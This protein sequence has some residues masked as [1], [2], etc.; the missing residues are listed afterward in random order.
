MAVS[1]GEIEDVRDLARV[2]GV[3]VAA[4]GEFVEG[5]PVVRLRDRSGERPL[6]PC[7]HD[8]FR[9]GPP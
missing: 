4:V 5:A 7:G 9:P 6:V 3:E 1:A 8:H 2:W